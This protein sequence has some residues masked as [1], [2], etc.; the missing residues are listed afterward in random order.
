MD[1]R[2]LLINPNTYKSP[3]VLPIGLEYLSSALKK[4]KYHCD[5]LDLT[6][7][8]KPLKKINDTLSNETYNIIGFSI[9]NIDSCLFFNNEFFL[10]EFKKMIECIKDYNI[11]VVLGGSGFSAMP[12]EILEYSKADFGI[13]G[14][15]EIAFSYFLKLWKSNQLTKKIMNGW[16]YGLDDELEMLRAK[17]IKYTRYIENGGIVGFSTHVGCSNGCPYCMEANKPV[18]YREIA[19]VIKEIEFL[20][21]QGYD[22]FHLCDSEFNENLSYSK[23]F[24]EAIIKNSLDLKWTLYMKPSPYDEELFRLL[25]KTNAHLIT[26]SVD[27]D[28]YLQSQNNYSYDDLEKIVQYC[29]KY[30]I[31]LAIDLLTGYPEE[32]L[33]STKKVIQF[34]KKNRP[35]TVGINFYYRLL[36]NTKLSHL[37]EEN[38]I[39]QKNLTRPYSQKEDFLTPIFYS[40]YKKEDIEELIRDDDL[41]KIPGITPGVNYQRE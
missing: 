1:L 9:R 35:K 34:F 39:I 12:D 10:D 18:Y 3:P 16:D 40:Q 17:E 13:I 21:K 38:P 22:Y 6:F 32:S 30:T 26:L 31:D 33:H 11:P 20:V 19:N 24:C 2:I 23:K 28:E 41:F 14:P 27:S 4:N 36:K 5:I 37:I 8:K 7:I 15:G 25:S 29:K